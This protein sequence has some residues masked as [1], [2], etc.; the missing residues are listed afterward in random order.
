MK[1]E[2][3][4][5]IGMVES[6]LMMMDEVYPIAMIYLYCIMAVCQMN[7]KNTEGARATFMKAFLWPDRINLL[8]HLS[9]ITDC[10]RGSWNPVFERLNHSY[11]RGFQI[12]LLHSAVGG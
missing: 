8:N 4:V 12:K 5:A 7:L 2:Y 3:E 10:F 11:I 1:K 6:A 9:N